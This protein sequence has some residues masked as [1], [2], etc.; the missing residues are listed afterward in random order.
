MVKSQQEKDKIN[1]PYQK[2]K[3]NAEATETH[4]LTDMGRKNCNMRM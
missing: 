4:Q 3:G 2:E 1:Q